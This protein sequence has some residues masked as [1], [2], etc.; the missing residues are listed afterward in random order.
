MANKRTRALTV[1]EYDQIIDTMRTGFAGCRPN[2]RIATALI[3]EANLGIRIS[4][5]LNLKLSDIVKEGS[6]YRLNITEQKTK[7]S[8]NF[9]V[10]FEI[11]QYIKIFELRPSLR[12]L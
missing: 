2:D 9:T 3:I 6:R 12:I 5:I 10:P 8:R 11:F 7:K 1:E 4:D